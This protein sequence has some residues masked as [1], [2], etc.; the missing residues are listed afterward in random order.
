MRVT[1]LITGLEEGG[2]ENTLWRLLSRTDRRRF[3]SD[4][5]SLRQD[6]PV[7]ERVRALGVKVT[8]LDLKAGSATLGALWSLRRHLA[9]RRPDVLQTWLYHADLAGALAGT[10]ARV[11]RIVWNVRASN[12]D[13]SRYPVMS[14]FTVRTCAQLARIPAAV[15]TNSAAAIDHHTHIGYRPR[16]WVLIPNGVDTSV[17]RPDVNARLSLRRELQLSPDARLIGCVG[18]HDPMKDHETFFAAARWLAPRHPDAH[19]VLAGPGVVGGN[20][21][22]AALADSGALTG[23]VHLLGPRTDIA[24]VLAALDL[25]ISSSA[26]GEGF[27]NVLAEGMACGVPCVATR[28]GDALQIVGKPEHV[29]APRDA[30]ALSRTADR[31]LSLAPSALQALGQDARARVEGTFHIDRMVERY[32]ALY[33][34]LQVQHTCAA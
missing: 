16:Q 7:A 26:F 2:A 5:V 15:V 21:A 11:P 4:V 1:H 8:S 33:N 3:D 18:R 31:L 27:P 17:F 9:V 14:G 30:D 20:A 22:L 12:M 24:Q 23:R 32:E 29:V 25:L 34:G 19:F 10:L 28:V 13:L 6:G